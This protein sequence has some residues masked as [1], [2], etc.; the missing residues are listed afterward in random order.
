[1]DKPRN[2]DVLY[3]EE[4]RKEGSV[5]HYVCYEG[6]KLNLA[7][8]ARHCRHDDTWSEISAIP[9]CTII[10]CSMPAKPHPDLRIVSFKRNK[11]AP[12]VPGDL[13]IYICDTN[14]VSKASAKCL[15][16]GEWSRGP[17]HCPQR[18]ECTSLSQIVHGSHNATAPYPIATIVKFECE[19]GYRI[20]GSPIIE[21]QKRGGKVMW[22]DTAPSCQEVPKP[23]PL[24]SQKF[25][26]LITSIVIVFLIVCVMFGVLLLRWRQRQLQRRRWQRY[27]GHY[28]HRQSK[29]NITLNTNE[30]KCF[31]QSP[32]PTVP[33]TDL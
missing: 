8:N 32:K 15:G 13:V 4:H 5:L 2:G 23:L 20:N 9:E 28:H 29:T 16:N 30:M 17:P 14:T 1:M 12:Y 26:A 25:T 3:S 10:T 11:S 33:V 24:K 6:H 7:N 31:R 27:F 18:N 21:C 19:D 22:N